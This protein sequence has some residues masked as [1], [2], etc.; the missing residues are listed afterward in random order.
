MPASSA[1]LRLTALDIARAIERCEVA[2][3]LACVESAARI[4]PEIGCETIALAGGIAAFVGVDAPLSQAL[5]LGMEAL[6]T[7]GDVERLTEF[8]ER[9]GST[10]AIILNP[11]ADPALGPL[12]A[13]AG[14][15]PVEYEST[16][17]AELDS[18][19]GMRDD[20]IAV[21]RDLRAW[22]QH[23]AR[24]FFNAAD[25]ELLAPGLA[26]V[27]EAIAS[28]RDV[29]PLEGRDPNENVVATGAMDVQGEWAG[30]FASSTH[31]AFRKQGWQTALI[32]D[33]IA[34]AQEAGCRYARAS[35]LA[36]SGSEENFRR[37]GF[38]VAYTRTTWQRK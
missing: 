20:R 34:R 14:Y 35:A 26:L 29:T 3:I 4:A 23:S 19:K 16:L 28:A 21:A 7:E 10:P 2:G 9:R 22:S 15:V 17:F 13:K 6:V 32:R 36:G 24:S 18:V 12:L 38:R 1:G 8:Y 31:V 33:R 27:G 37:C 30:L 11:L 25:G 5:A